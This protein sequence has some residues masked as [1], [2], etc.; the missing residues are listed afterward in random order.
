MTARVVHKFGGTSLADASCFRRVAE[1]V[2]AR[3]ESHRAVVVSAMSGVTNALIRAVQLAGAREVDG[4]SSVLYS[5]QKKAHQLLTVTVNYHN[6]T[7]VCYS[8][9]KRV[10]SKRKVT[11][12]ARG[13]NVED[14]TTLEMAII[15]YQI[16]KEKIETKIRE[17][18]AQLKGKRVAMPSAAAEKKTS[19]KRVLSPGA[20]RRIAAAQKKRWAEHRKRAAA[21]S[22]GE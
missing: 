10:R 18:Q 19:V 8:Y 11:N 5:L 2:A 15:G 20:R 9:A 21:A 12:M 4:Y 6:L 13:K 17:L 16:E 7:P 1:I 22:K 14:S 3:P